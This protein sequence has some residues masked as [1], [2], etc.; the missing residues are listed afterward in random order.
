M[1]A[2]LLCMT[3][4]VALC[5]QGG[6]RGWELN[7]FGGIIDDRPDFSVE[8]ADFELAHEGVIGFRVGHGLFSAFFLEGELLYAP[9]ELAF[10]RE[11]GRSHH[12]LR[13][14]FFTGALGHDF[15][16]LPRLQFFARVGM[17]G[18]RWNGPDSDEV[19]F[20]FDF[21][22]GARYFIDPRIAVRAD[23]RWHYLP[24]ALGTVRRELRPELS[25]PAENLWLPELSG[26]LSVFFGG[27]D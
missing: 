15:Q 2:V 11:P 4:T 1:I 8:G 24:S 27:L 12:E 13:A 20:A 17:G 9:M 5:A 16:L 7:A 25:T 18:V 19:D 3:G 21:G 23:V 10:D 14:L 22:G 6:L 26:G